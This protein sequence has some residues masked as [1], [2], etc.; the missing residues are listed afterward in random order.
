MISFDKKG[1]IRRIN[2][3]HFVQQAIS[4]KYTVNDFILENRKF[5]F[6]RN[7]KRENR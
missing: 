6:L 2:F 5:N 1:T 3:C 4:A 7:A